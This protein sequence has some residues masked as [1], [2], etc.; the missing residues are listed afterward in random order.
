MAFD[1]DKYLAA[2]AAKPGGFDPDAYLAAPKTHSL[3]S[4]SADIKQG[5][6]ALGPATHRDI[7]QGLSSMVSSAGNAATLGLYDKARS[8][9]NRLLGMETPL[10]QEQA[11]R[12]GHPSL[13][14]AGK[15]MGYLAPQGIPSVIGRT[16]ATGLGQAAK[17]A[18][19][20]IRSLMAARPVAG[21]IGGGL[22]GGATTA[23]EDV[24]GGVPLREIPKDVGRSALTGAVMGGTIGTV[25]AG[26][27]KAR[28]ALRNPQ[29][30]IGRSIAAL[31]Q[32]K[33]SGVMNTPEFKALPHGAEGFNR[34]ATTAEEQLAGHNE[35]ILNHA[36]QQYGQHI[37]QILA[38]HANK[39]YDFTKLH[40]ELGGIESEMVASNGTVGDPHMK[41]AI[42]RVR[43]M[44][45][46]SVVQHGDSF[47]LSG[48]PAAGLRTP[49]GTVED[50]IKAQKVIK[51]DAQY[52][53][54]P[55]VENRPYRL[56]DKLLSEEG[57]DI[58]PRLR[59]LKADY[60]KVVD[61]LGEA[62]DIMYGSRDPDVVRNTSKQ[63][64]ARGLLGRI[65][66]STQA[67]TLAEQDI[68]RL[69]ALDPK[70]Q[71]ILSPV[72]AK[73]AVERTRF[74]LPHVSRRIEHLPFA[75]LQQNAAALGT[76]VI[77]PA[78][79]Q[80]SGE[81]TPRAMQAGAASNPLMRAL[82]EKRK[83]DAAMAASL[84]ASVQ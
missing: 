72:E 10:A 7:D 40:G 71:E 53:A 52:D 43:M 6:A 35:D 42:D 34:A 15:A 50:L 68:A 82:E 57:K 47:P 64:R 60:A 80:L 65:G 4:L 46:Q 27:T 20:A 69:K 13:D 77:D 5:Q 30:E 8:G 41:N 3:D 70:Y 56:L 33:A 38:E 37:D 2:P 66:D 67:A 79:A 21:A 83:R 81:L 84:G 58:D 12:E 78:L 45:S 63:K 29:N 28:D 32:A 14:A 24:A 75:A 22:T 39:R 74:G 36:R 9:I 26:A 1:P 49:A 17:A 16:V 76:H 25:A 54:A 44:T 73:K 48:Q 19:A 51:A 59:P 31:D 62:N 18:P 61:Q 11:F 23:A 55:T